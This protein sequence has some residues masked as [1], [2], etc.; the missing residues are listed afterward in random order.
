VSRDDLKNFNY[1][2]FANSLASQAENVVPSDINPDDKEFIISLI[3]RFCI[4]AGEALVKDEYSKLDAD[5]VSTV[6][7]YIGEWIFHKSIDII[8]A[9]IEPQYREKILQRVA[10]IV[11][12]V[13]KQ[14]IENETSEDYLIGLVE[15]AVNRV[16]EK[17]LRDLKDKGVLSE[18]I[19]KDTLQQ[20]NIDDMAAAE[21][22]K[23]DIAKD[24]VSEEITCM[25][26]NIFVKLALLSPKNNNQ[27]FK[28]AIFLENEAIENDE[29]VLG[30]DLNYIE[31]KP[32]NIKVKNEENKHK[33]NKH[34][35]N[36]KPLFFWNTAAMLLIIPTVYVSIKGI[37][38]QRFLMYLNFNFLALA[39]INYKRNN[40]SKEAY[41]KYPYLV[42]TYMATLIL[43]VL[44]LSYFFFLTC[45]KFFEI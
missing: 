14:G 23:E 45:I 30:F 37:N 19:L 31:Q 9:G 18:E 25:S 27:L 22:N 10:F 12:E 38:L 2:D 5:G 34:K 4:M 16:F 11:Y 24:R 41:D 40:I 13:A 6:V 32:N 26:D 8:R 35:T 43:F 28:N 7:Q 21:I 36:I 15:N 17:T 44:C 20:S 29:N 1:K 42:L 33:N 39:Y 3:Q